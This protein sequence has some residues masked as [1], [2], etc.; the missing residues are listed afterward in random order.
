LPRLKPAGKNETKT[1]VSL[2]GGKIYAPVLVAQSNFRDFLN[3]NPN[4]GG[5]ANNIHAYFNYVGANPDRVD[6]FRALGNNTFAVEDMY[7]GGD[8]DFNDGVV[9]LNIRPA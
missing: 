5:G 8:R 2:T 6:R 1:D 3:N 4:N 7:G 9:S